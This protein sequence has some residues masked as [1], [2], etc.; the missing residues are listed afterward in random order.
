MLGLRPN[1][2]RSILLSAIFLLSLTSCGTSEGDTSSTDGTPKMVMTA[3]G[4]EL[5]V[6]TCCDSECETPENFC[7]N[8]AHCGGKCDASLPLWDDETNAPKLL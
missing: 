5:P 8:E 3:S 4:E 2:M 1:L 7:C 6:G